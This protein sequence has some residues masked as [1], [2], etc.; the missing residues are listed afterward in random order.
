[1]SPVEGDDSKGK[2]DYDW[3]AE[4]WE[5]AALGALAPKIEEPTLTLVLPSSI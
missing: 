3:G 1:M 5:E 2:L 4:G